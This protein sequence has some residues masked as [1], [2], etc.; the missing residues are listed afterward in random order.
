MITGPTMTIPATRAT[1]LHGRIRTA[2]CLK[3]SE[4]PPLGIEIVYTEQK[5]DSFFPIIEGVL[6][7][8]ECGGMTTEEKV[9]VVYYTASK[10]V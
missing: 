3:L 10:N 1:F 8:S 4:D 9:T 7:K 2:K 6:E 5:T